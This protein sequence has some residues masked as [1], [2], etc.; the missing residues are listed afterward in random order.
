MSPSNRP[1]AASPSLALIAALVLSGAA[2]AADPPAKP[3][4]T[5]PWKVDGEHGASKTISFSTDEG[6]WLALDVA[7]DGRRIVLSLLGDLYLLPI[8][9]GD[10]QRITS[11]P[12][13]DVQPRFSPD[14]KWIAFASDRGGTENL[15]IC[16]LD[17][18]SARAITTETERPVS[19]P[20]FS[21]DGEYLVGRKRI[22]DVSP[23]GTVELWMWH[24]KGG[25]GI[26]ITRKEDQPEAADPVFS[27]DGRF[28]YFSARPTRYNYNRNV[29][30]G[31][32]QIK[33][34][35]RKLGLSSPLTG[36]FGGAAAPAI[37]PD[38]T[39]MAFVR[40]VRAVTRIEL[41][42]LASGTTRLLADGVERDGQEGFAFHGVFPGYSW[43]P[44]GAALVL[45]AEGKIWK[46][47]AASG[48]RTAIPF[49][50]KVEQRVA[51]AVRFPQKIEGDVRAR[52]LRWPVES[53]DGKRLVFSAVG[54][55]YAMDLPSG[56]PARLTA[57]AD[58]EYA[59]AFSPDGRT[60]AYVTW[61]DAEGGAVMTIPATGTPAGGRPVRLTQ[62]KGQYANPSFSRDGKWIVYLKGSGATFRDE[63]PIAELWEEIRLVPAT[64][65]TSRY[66]IQT[67]NRGANRRMARPA[68]SADGERI[69]YSE[70]E[71]G[72]PGESPKTVLV[73]VKL[74]GTD[75][76][77]PLRF[78]YAEDVAV[79][80]DGRWIA[81]N[82]L[83]NAY[84]APLLQLGGST[85]DVALESGALPV[86][87]LTDEGGEWVSWVDGGKSIAWIFGPVY[88]RIALDKA[89]PAPNP[90]EETAAVPSKDDRAK[91]D[92]AKD[93]PKPLP[94]SD[95][96][97]I[98]LTLPRARP[99]ETVAYTGARIVTMKG[100]EVLE[101][102]T[103]VVEN[104]RIRAVGPTGRVPIPA[105]TRTVDLAGRTIIPGMFDEHAHLH[106]SAADIIPQRPWKYLANLA[107][108]VT[109]THDPSASTH[110]VFSQSEMVEAGLMTGPR[111]FSTGYI[112]YG[113]DDPERAVIKSLDDA[114]KHLRRLKSL[115]AF[116]VKSYMQP[117]REQRQWIIQAAREEGMMVV[118]EGGGDLESDMSM[119]L[120]GHTTIEHALPVTPLRKDV[121]TV[122]AQSG[123]SYTPTLLVA[124]GGFF[125]DRWF[126]QH[127]EIW[128]DRQLLNVTPQGVVDQLGRI[129][130]V[131]ATDE[132]WHHIDVA[133]SAKKVVDAGGRVNLGGHG[134]LQGLGPHWEMWAFV[135]GGMTPLQALRVATLSPAETLGLDRDLGSI[136][137]GKLADFV[138]L[139]KNPLERIENSAS[140][141][142]VVK[143]G[144]AST[145]ADLARVR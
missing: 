8:G 61:N 112:L 132:D 124:Y 18:K 55:L 115:G 31:I 119:V 11:G 82:E 49:D 54:H 138:V 12:A 133:A 56:K 139:S 121:V 50:A 111:I 26:Q 62:V 34:F 29:N 80:P 51:D 120:D 9:G 104:D 136:E 100:D 99:S 68:F 45:T 87:K 6:T 114:R 30:D 41:M 134:Q 1:R 108:G 33:R 22:I 140:I 89:L 39:T 73:S 123:T 110:E 17:G 84:V 58:L 60:I 98:A 47:A 53:P 126:F 65:G 142:L 69:Y 75:K 28:I 2:F 42:D 143:N 59:P 83:H 128:K 72:K 25:S 97:E 32:W 3:D 113:A 63:D 105:G 118:P 106:Y 93:K 144:T 44:D 86:A 135:Q 109:S 46:Y 14:G 20:A 92:K 137:A 107:Y 71:P 102:G 7:P 43:T 88:H 101:S 131:M 35:D 57:S 77:K 141:E 4:S 16:D 76:Q 95:S 130:T 10:A 96:F 125:G 38:G 5:K 37:S 91:D 13:Y 36:E 19:S 21:P 90:E 27:P 24:V 103:L 67:A 85:I 122:L 23:L 79:S 70:D 66:V 64:G 145:L 129:R 117:R 48:A 15:W 52:I 94:A 74:D 116:S 40:R 127:Y 81:W 78:T